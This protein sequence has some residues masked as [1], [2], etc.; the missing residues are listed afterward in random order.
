MASAS[1]FMAVPSF[2]GDGDDVAWAPPA[3]GRAATRDDDDDAT[4][5]ALRD[6]RGDARDARV[7]TAS[8]AARG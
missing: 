2:D 5:V 6:G 8:T 4:A 7:A 1:A 3:A